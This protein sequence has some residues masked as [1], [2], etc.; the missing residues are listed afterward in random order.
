LIWGPAIQ[1]RDGYRA[2][3][4]AITALITEHPRRFASV[5]DTYSIP[6]VR[7]RTKAEQGLTT[8]HLTTVDGQRVK[9]NVPVRDSEEVIGCFTV[10]PGVDVADLPR[11]ARSWS[12]R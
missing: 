12:A 3:H 7:P 2:E 5:M 4:A 1:H 9:L 6:A 8:E 11:T 10:A